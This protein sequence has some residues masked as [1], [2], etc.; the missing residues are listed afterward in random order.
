MDDK[1]SANDSLITDAS[2]IL[3]ITQILSDI[4]SIGKETYDKKKIKQANRKAADQL[5]SNLKKVEEVKTIWQYEKEINLRNFYHPSKVKI[6]DKK[7][8]V[9]PTF[10]KDISEQKNFIVE[11]MAGQG[12]SILLRYIAS[13]ELRLSK[14]IPIFIELRKI[15]ESKLLLTQI[16]L[17]LKGLGFHIDDEILQSLL[18]SGKVSLLLD[19]FDEISKDNVTK[20]LSQIEDI[21]EIFPE[22]QIIVTSRPDSG[23]QNSEL[24]RVVKIAQLEPFD[25]LPFLRKICSDDHQAE[26]IYTALTESPSDIRMLIRTPLLLTLLTIVF[27][28]E[29]TIPSSFTDFYDKL[30]QILYT[31][32]DSSKPGF[33]R[34]KRSNLSEEK[35]ERAF[36]VFCFLT[37]KDDKTTLTR[38]EA[39][40]YGEKS[41]DS[42]GLAFDSEDFL[43]DITKITCLLIQEGFQ[44]HF[45]HKSVQEYFSSRF[46]KALPEEAAT[47]FYLNARSHYSSWPQ[48]LFFLKSIDKYRCFKYFLSP[49]LEAYIKEYN[50][51]QG[52]KKFLKRFE[53]EI[54]FGEKVNSISWMET[55]NIEKFYKD[56]L[57]NFIANLF[58]KVLRKFVVDENIYAQARI[59]KNYTKD[60][61]ISE[62][63][64]EEKLAI[65]LEEIFTIIEREELLISAFEN[66]IKFLNKQLKECHEE[67]KR[68]ESQ[69]DLLDF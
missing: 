5:Y 27:N 36:S 40:L 41:S 13:N 67:I 22:T 60:R 69:T 65:P 49:E 6:K 4:Y 19:G 38:S 66:Y 11:G 33:K 24:F 55:G 50:G 39:L 16:E 57:E 47:K 42:S 34:D 68:Q 26:I 20:I 51:I 56:N 43:E 23:V 44:Y 25:H 7:G 30:F 3:A 62:N 12:K 37:R 52:R 14:R 8:L 9:E 15:D 58:S 63:S 48:E 17:R 28:A 29:Q 1:S 10:I 18:K 31:R 59:V 35:L 2:G 45:I 61:L 54:E 53:V 32:H 46:I 21:A 64:S